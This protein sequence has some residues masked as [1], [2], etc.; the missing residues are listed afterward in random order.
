MDK[1]KDENIAL[2][3]KTNKIMINERYEASNMSCIDKI[4]KFIKSHKFQ[5]IIIILVV[6]DALAVASE[7]ILHEAEQHFIP[8]KI[9]ACQSINSDNNHLVE[10]IIANGSINNVHK[11]ELSQNG[12][13]SKH[14]ENE[15]HGKHESLHTIFKVLESI[16]THITLI[17]LSI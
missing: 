17:I 14:M 12:S 8:H 2:S 7:L 6:I 3:S 16:L 4:R 1:T 15:D 13:H 5:V 9:H 10:N 11:V